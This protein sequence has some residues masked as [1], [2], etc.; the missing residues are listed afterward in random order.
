MPLKLV[1]EMVSF[2]GHEDLLFNI[3]DFFLLKPE[4]ILLINGEGEESFMW[5]S[6]LPYLSFAG[7]LQM[8][9]TL[10]I[11]WKMSEFYFFL[12]S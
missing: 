4:L 7:A 5:T 11:I 12:E 1:V 2:Q 6:T 3:Y 8:H 10:L 9:F